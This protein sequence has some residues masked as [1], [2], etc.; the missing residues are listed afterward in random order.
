MRRIV[1]LFGGFLLVAVAA[2]V[3]AA[4]ASKPVRVPVV[5]PEDLTLEGVCPF[6]LA[7]HVLVNNEKTTTYS[8]GSMKIT[9][10]WKDVVSNG[11]DPSKSYVDNNSAPIMITP[12]ADGSTHV[13]IVGQGAVYFFPGNLGPGS[14]GVL[15]I[16]NGKLEETIDSAGNIVPG[17][18]HYN[19][20][21]PL[22]LCA[23]LA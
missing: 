22:D 16:T 23:A 6:P 1:C 3:P 15:W 2:V 12:A 10:T 14:P 17:S 11:N 8:D 18:V 13:K 19:G 20:K 5:A 21:T 7:I 4:T 9:G